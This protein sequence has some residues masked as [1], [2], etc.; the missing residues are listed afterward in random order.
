MAKRCQK[1]VLPASAPKIN[2]DE[3]NI[4]SYCRSHK[5]FIYKG[6]KELLKFLKNIRKHRKGNYDC[7]VPISGG[8]DSMYTLLKIVKDYNMKVLAVN[9][10]NPFTDPIAKKNIKNAIDILNLDFIGFKLQN[11]R[12]EKVF[13]NNLKAWL[14]N[15][16]PAMLFM[17]C[18]A[19]KDMDWKLLEIARKNNIHYIISGGNPFEDMSFQK[20]LI[21]RPG[22]EQINN[23]IINS[24]FYIFREILKNPKYL[25][26]VT[27]QTYVRCI[28][29][30]FF[31]PHMLKMFN[32]KSV[33][34]FEF[35]EWKENNV[36]SRIKSELN[37][38]YS[39]ELDATWRFDCKIEYLKDFLYQKT[40]GM[41]E[42]DEFYSRIIRERLMSRKEVLDRLKKE[43]NFK[44]NLIKKFLK[45]NDLEDINLECFLN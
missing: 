8:R 40:I 17:I 39:H 27:L 37:W 10:E 19:C 2:F 26:S 31:Y 14:K 45:E 43:N 1:C 16:S 4:C 41:T 33:N 13:E 25:N 28:F 15:P 44:L 24:S 20:E 3:N 7:V 5:K 23:T 38:D 42:K 11:K 6:E 9:Y 32:I 36:I 21:N 18:M 22:N 12:H 34:L 30:T 29:Y 35:I